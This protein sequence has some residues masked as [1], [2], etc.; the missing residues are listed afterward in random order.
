MKSK[1]F[2]KV[3]LVSVIVVVAGIIFSCSIKNKNT[4]SFS[5]QKNTESLIEE[6]SIEEQSV[7][8]IC[9]HVCGQVKSPGVYY[10]NNGARIHDAVL[11]AGG[12]KDEADIQYLNLAALIND[13]EQIYIPSID[14]VSSGKVASNTSSNFD[15]GLVN[16]NNAS[17]DELKTLPGIGDIKAKAIISYR[18]SVGSFSNIEDIKN[19]AGIKDS[20][21]EKIKD[22]IKV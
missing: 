6:S 5:E 15:D 9:I 13:G 10:L 12:F 18:E 14:E 4:K 1:K 16:L 11:A 2:I 3:L 22:Y 7:V 20:S 21:Y 8:K 19:V 17:E